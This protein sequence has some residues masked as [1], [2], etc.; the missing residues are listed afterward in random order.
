M[1]SG[2]GSNPGTG[3][4]GHRRKFRHASKAVTEAAR[5]WSCS[6]F[7]HVN[8]M[9]LRSKSFGELSCKMDHRRCYLGKINSDQNAF[10]VAASSIT[11]TAL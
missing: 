5:H 9:N 10:H 2:I 11:A 7:S 4:A 3:T 6:D 8:K 1:A